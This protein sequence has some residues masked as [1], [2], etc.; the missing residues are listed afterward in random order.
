MEWSNSM[1]KDFVSL[2]SALCDVSVVN[3]PVFSDVF[4]VKSDV[5]GVGVG[6]TK[7]F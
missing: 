1:E 7:C 2:F 5:P 6:C 4:I 3:V